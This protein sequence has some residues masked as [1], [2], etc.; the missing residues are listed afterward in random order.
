MAC[1]II[2]GDLTLIR[3]NR[4]TLREITVHLPLTKTG[5]A[6]KGIMGI[7]VTRTTLMSKIYTKRDHSMAIIMVGQ[8]VV[9]N[10]I[11]NKIHIKEGK[12]DNQVII[13][14]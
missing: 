13:F 9:S 1:R 10:R 5:Q 4:P 8:L 14:I 11:T 3:T 7:M 12:Y 2:R 6:F